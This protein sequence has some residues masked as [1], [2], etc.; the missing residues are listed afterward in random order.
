MFKL[1]TKIVVYVFKIT[2][3]I[4]TFFQ[5][6]LIVNSSVIYV[7]ILTKTNFTGKMT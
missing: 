5:I 7:A 6:Q 3:N 4:G 1:N 2:V